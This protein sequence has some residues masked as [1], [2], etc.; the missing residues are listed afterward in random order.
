MKEGDK[1]G[2]GR[3]K[4]RKGKDVGI[5]TNRAATISNLQMVSLRLEMMNLLH[6]V[7]RV[8]AHVLTILVNCRL[9]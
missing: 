6:P 3:G 5:T 2:K 8:R 9:P 4:G 7:R 1:E